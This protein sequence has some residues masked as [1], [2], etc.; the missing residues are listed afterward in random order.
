MTDIKK[1]VTNVSGLQ[2]FQLLRFGTLFLVGIVFAKSYLST[3]DIGRYETFLFLAGSVTFFWLNGIIAS[4]LP[5]HKN[6]ESFKVYNESD[7]SPE[8]F[9][10][11]LLLIFFS[12]IASMLVYN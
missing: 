1:Y 6:N 10:A 3:Q 7:K 12:A 5:V 11:F 9:N 4:L 2:Y 8:F